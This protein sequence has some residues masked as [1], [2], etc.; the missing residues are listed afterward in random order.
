MDFTKELLDVE[1]TPLRLPEDA[2]LGKNGDAWTAYKVTKFLLTAQGVKDDNP[3]G[4]QKFD[5]A[6]LLQRVFKDQTKASLSEQEKA[7]LKE[8]S[9]KVFGPAIVLPFWNFLDEK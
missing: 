7:L 2:G 5:R 8:L 6:M 3:T 1:G 4:P 9:G